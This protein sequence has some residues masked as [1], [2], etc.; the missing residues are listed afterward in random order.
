MQMLIYTRVWKEFEL[1][2]KKGIVVM[3]SHNSV[4]T[5]RISW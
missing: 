1:L 2:G 4:V 5:Y 3:K